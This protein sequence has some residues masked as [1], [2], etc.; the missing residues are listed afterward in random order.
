MLLERAS[1][2]PARPLLNTS[3]CV[4]VVRRLFVVSRVA[5]CSVAANRLPRKREKRKNCEKIPVARRSST[6]SIHHE[7]R[8][9]AILHREI[10]KGEEAL[11]AAGGVRRDRAHETSDWQVLRKAR[12]DPAVRDS[13]GVRRF[14]HE[15]TDP[16][17]EGRLRVQA[18]DGE[19]AVRD[20][21]IYIYIRTYMRV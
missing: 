14:D 10:R 2:L 12:R 20:I 8:E 9:T 1:R 16:H 6:E 5:F 17:A 15:T 13:A 7:S 19:Y 11:S 3:L 21:Y 18:P 4:Y